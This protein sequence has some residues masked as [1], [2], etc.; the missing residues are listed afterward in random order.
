MCIYLG[1]RQRLMPEQ[2]LDGSD[3]GAVVQH[4]G[5]ERVAEN[6]GRAL[7]GADSALECVV[8]DRVDQAAVKLPAVGSHKEMD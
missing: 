3:V 2:L 6:V 1:C 8:D 4:V 5:G 7:R